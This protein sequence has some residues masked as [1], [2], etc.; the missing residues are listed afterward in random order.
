MR[1]I[2]SLFYL[3]YNVVVLLNYQYILNILNN[4][5][6]F[7]QDVLHLFLKIFDKNVIIF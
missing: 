6:I 1:Y 7:L 5:N 3:S 2:V 4:Y